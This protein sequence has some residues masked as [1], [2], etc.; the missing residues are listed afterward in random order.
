MIHAPVLE[1]S[2]RFEI[3]RTGRDDGARELEYIRARITLIWGSWFHTLE[4]AGKYSEILIVCLLI[5][6]V[7]D[8]MVQGQTASRLIVPSTGTTSVGST[9]WRLATDRYIGRLWLSFG[10]VTLPPAVQSTSAASPLGPSGIP[11]LILGLVYYIL[12]YISCAPCMNKPL[13]YR[14]CCFIVFRRKLCNRYG[15]THQ[16]ASSVKLWL[17]WFTF[18]LA[19]LTGPVRQIKVD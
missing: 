12:L 6:N 15:D 2:S 7:H 1:G 18:Y 4:R 17:G 9:P 3:A 5:T 11:E 13:S 16:M 19:E 14:L 8:V 10:Y